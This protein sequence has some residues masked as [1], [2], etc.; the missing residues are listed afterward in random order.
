MAKA[1]RGGVVNCSRLPYLLVIMPVSLEFP[2]YKWPIDTDHR[3][4]GRGGDTDVDPRLDFAFMEN[5]SARSQR[6]K[7]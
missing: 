7:A 1:A 4:G 2:G 3:Q 5:G 6:V